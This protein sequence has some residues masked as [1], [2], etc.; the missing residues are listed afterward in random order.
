[1]NINESG[2]FYMGNKTEIEYTRTTKCAQVYSESAAEYVLPDYN[3]DVRKI[4]YTNAEVRP[5]AK[6]ASGDEVECSGI[7]VYEMIYL[8]TENALTSVSFTS[9]YDFSVKCSGEN[10]RDS[11]VD[12]AIS[13]FSLRLIG[14]RKIAAKSS[15]VGSVRVSENRRAAIEG[16]AFEG[17]APEMQ[18]FRYSIR[19]S[20]PSE[21]HERE[22]AESVAKL[23]GAIVDEVSVIATSADAICEKITSGDG[24]ITVSGSLT[25]SAVIKNGDS[26]AYQR[27]RVVP[28]EERIPFA[29]VDS[30]MKF[31][32]EIS[33]SS[34]VATVNANESGVDVVLSAIV[35]MSAVGEANEAG[36]IVTDAYLKSFA[37]DNK[38]EEFSYSELS[39]VLSSVES[40]SGS[41]QRS[42]IEAEGIRE[43]LFLKATPK[44]EAVSCENGKVNV[45]GELKYSGIASVTDGDGSFS[46]IPLRFSLPFER[47]FEV[48]SCDNLSS[49]VRVRAHGAGATFDAS[50]LYVSCNLEV[51]LLTCEEKR[52]KRLSS[53]RKISEQPFEKNDSRIVIYYPDAN[54]S[55]FS[56]AKKYRTTVGKIASDNSLG[57]EAIASFDGD[58]VKPGLRKLLIY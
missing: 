54:E 33:V 44:I 56:I 16:D 34:L 6:F 37:V 57:V 9:D 58:G 38:Y 21:N 12:T 18:T 23:D 20:A 29:D 31:V 25:L 39:D 17:D 42:E 3:G 46:Y 55:L 11:F 8:D 14:P 35:D 15:V 49:D 1:M 47:S 26:P 50:K 52:V 32:P 22:F 40:E 7:V 19:K 30:D 4:L 2:A 24:E 10:Y 51:T 36:E 48:K 27:E 5:S 43:I 13:N 53:S 41:V 28:F 45:S